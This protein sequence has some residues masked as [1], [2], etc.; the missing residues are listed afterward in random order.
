[1]RALAAL[2]ALVLLAAGCSSDSAAT[3]DRPLLVAAASDLQ[4]AFTELGEVYEEQTGRPVTFTFGSSGQLSQQVVNGAPF[5]VFASA[6]EAYVQDVL[7]AGQAD[8]ATQAQYARGRIVVWTRDDAGP[9]VSLADLVQPRFRR[10]AIANPEHAPY[11]VAAEQALQ[12][13]GL[14]ERVRDRLVYGESVSDTLRLAASGNADAA[15][16]ALSLATV[17]DG[18]RWTEVPASAHS[19]LR[20]ALVATADEERAGAAR[21]FTQL[22]T[23][24]R[25]RAVLRRYGFAPPEG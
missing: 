18:G 7:D 22:V 11:G 17:Q 1:V 12:S 25:G 16:V 3:A 13:S 23:S 15:I 8:P 20:Q 24:E 4:P 14:H 5:E 10:I 6:D 2:A 19:P 9:R 21:A